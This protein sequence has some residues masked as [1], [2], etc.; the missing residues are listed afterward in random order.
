MQVG[1]EQENHTKRGSGGQRGGTGRIRDRS[2]FGMV[3]TVQS[4]LVRTYAERTLDPAF[5][6]EDRARSA[7]WVADIAAHAF[8]VERIDRW[9]AAADRAR[10]LA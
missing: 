4:A 2:S 6:A 5:S 1:P 7:H 10:L 8:T 9:L 3:L